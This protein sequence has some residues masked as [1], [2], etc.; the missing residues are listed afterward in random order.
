[1]RSILGGLCLRR[2]LRSPRPGVRVGFAVTWFVLGALVALGCGIEESREVDVGRDSG[3][4]DVRVAAA[5]NFA[6]PLRELSRAF[7]KETGLR[8]EAS[9]ASTGKLYAQI[10]AGA[11]FDVFLSADAARAEQLVADGLAD[12]D[13]LRRYATGSLV[14]VAHV[15]R[16]SPGEVRQTRSPTPSHTPPDCLAPLLSGHTAPDSAL[17]LANPDTAPYGRAARQTLERLGLWEGL[18]GRLVRG[19]NV[20]QALQ[21]VDTGNAAAGFVARSQFVAYR[22]DRLSTCAWSVPTS[23]HAPI[24]Q[25]MVV[26][27]RSA[28]RPAAL[29]FARFMASDEA[30]RILRESGYTP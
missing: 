24:E 27:T 4:V 5:S 14:L 12:A 28:S 22:G 30:A 8:V 9:T 19:E 10:R 3:A 16:V 15:D 7:S 13:S 29:A 23:L 6:L 20:S 2:A 18:R 11:P 21:F 26:L 17:A 25:K 1:M